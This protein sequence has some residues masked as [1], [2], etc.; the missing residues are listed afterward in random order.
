MI[1]QA[2]DEMAI[3]DEFT[4]TDIFDRLSPIFP[5]NLQALNQNVMNALRRRRASGQIE[6]VGRRHNGRSHQHLYRKTQVQHDNAVNTM[7]QPSMAVLVAL[8]SLA[9]HIEEYL[10]PDGH[11]NDKIAIESLL[12]G[13]ELRAF[14]AE[15]DKL[16]FLPRKRNL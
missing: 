3:G 14:L 4:T 13:G 11:P 15:M 5:K 16:A 9:I 2:I 10:S 7:L 8:G 6:F 12:A 1:E